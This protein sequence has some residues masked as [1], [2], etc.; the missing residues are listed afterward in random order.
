MDKI[1][2]V[3]GYNDIVKKPKKSKKKIE[4]ELKRAKKS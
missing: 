4:K 3:S 1:V 2:I